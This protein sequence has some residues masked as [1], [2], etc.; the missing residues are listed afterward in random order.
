MKLLGED[1]IVSAVKVEDDKNILLLTELG[2]GKRTSFDNFMPHARGTMGQRIYS[3]NEDDKVVGA[4]SVTDND[5]V[6]LITMLGQVLRVAVVNI[7][8]Q[9]KNAS[10]VIVAKFKKKNDRVN[11][12]DV[13]LHEEV[14]LE[15][16][17]SAD[18]EPTEE[19]TEE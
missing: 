17:E 12:L 5:D 1:E 2:K 4:V 6:I 15:D 9:G 19:N 18:E 7:S 13:T 11:A 16:E 8:N 10:G 3:L 14:S